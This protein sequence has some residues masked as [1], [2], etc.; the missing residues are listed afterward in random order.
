MVEERVVLGATNFEEMDRMRTTIEGRSLK[1]SSAREGCF[2]V[3]I[4]KS[5]KGHFLRIKNQEKDQTKQRCRR[6]D[7][8]D[9]EGEKVEKGE[10]EE[11]KNTK[12]P[13]VVFRS[14]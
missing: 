11:S 8:D 3:G 4:Y 12:Q 10:G 5:Y 7:D 1:S 13:F 9:V 6:A 14:S 2:G